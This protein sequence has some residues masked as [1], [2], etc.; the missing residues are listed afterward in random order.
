MRKWKAGKP[1]IES[2]YKI[3]PDELRKELKKIGIIADISELK[4]KEGG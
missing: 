3:N 1:K 2:V 4:K